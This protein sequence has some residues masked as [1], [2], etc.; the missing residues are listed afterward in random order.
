MINIYVFA[1]QET[2][3]WLNSAVRFLWLRYPLKVNSNVLFCIYVF[4]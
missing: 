4:L 1:E 3:E 2:V